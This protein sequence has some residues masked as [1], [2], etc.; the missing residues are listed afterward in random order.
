M[1][2]ILFSILFF[3]FGYAGI[4]LYYIYVKTVNPVYR[5]KSGIGRIVRDLII[6]G[7]VTWTII[8]GIACVTYVFLYT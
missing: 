4:P 7:I 6:C 2:D 3:L 1:K 5:G 8:L